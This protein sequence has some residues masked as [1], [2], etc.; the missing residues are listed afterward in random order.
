MAVSKKSVTKPAAS[1]SS[2]AK[3]TKT[4]K[5]SV[6]PSGKMETTM[7]VAR[8]ATLARNVVAPF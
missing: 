4:T 7:R 8:T 5:S 6:A 2:K 1:K 3:T